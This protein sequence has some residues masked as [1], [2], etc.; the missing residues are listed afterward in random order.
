MAS[1]KDSIR[2]QAENDL[3]Y[4]ACLL[5]PV[6]LYGEL[7]KEVFRWLMDTSNPNQLLLLPRA[8][9]K[10]HCIAIWAAWWITKYPETTILYLSATPELAESQL[11]VIKDILTSSIYTRYWPNMVLQ[12]EGKREKWTSTKIAVDHPKRKKEGVRDATVSA[13]GL[14]TNT[15]GSHADI[16]IPDDIVVPDNAYTE[17][18]RRKVASAMSQMASI[19]NTGGLIKACGTRYHP[20]DQYSLWIKQKVPI[21]DN[22]GDIIDEKPIWDIF[23]RVVEV[24]G[25]FLWPRAYRDDG[26]AFG[27]D[28]RELARIS[29]MYTD[30]TQFY[31]Q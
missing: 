6:R 15:T 21:F 12:D 2:E 16:I 8:H 10:S 26:K 31:A 20:A 24:E 11:K 9:M 1:T 29:A 23:E 13:A 5:N 27:F 30:R 3:Y 19:L 4:F 18:G 14:T 22:N 7:H 28:R 17:E 25:V